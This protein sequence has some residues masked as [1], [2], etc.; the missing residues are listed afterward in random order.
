MAIPPF[1]DFLLATL[2]NYSDRQVHTIVDVQNRLADDFDLSDADRTE[3]LES[4]FQTRLNNRVQWAHT[5]LSRSKLLERVKR[6]Q[7]RISDRGRALLDEKPREVSPALLK[8]RYSEFRE[9][10]SPNRT[11]GSELAPGPDVST[12]ASEAGPGTPEERLESNYRALRVALAQQLVDQLKASSPSFFERV[13][14]ELLVAM[15]YG[16]SRADAGK[17]VGRSGDGGID[18]IIKED[19]LGLDAVYIQAKRWDS[20]VG[21]PIVQGFVGALAGRKAHKGILITTSSF[22]QEARRYVEDIP[23]KVILIDGAQLAEYMMDFGVGVATTATYA[24]RRIDS[25]FFEET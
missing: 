11:G 25:D 24:V 5:Y 22:S 3:M 4:G 13:V 18:G 7:Y 6:S 21:R 9:F 8:E 1:K 19:R 2:K 20:Q 17:A 16:G 23:Q 15:G 14:V 12:S 10:V